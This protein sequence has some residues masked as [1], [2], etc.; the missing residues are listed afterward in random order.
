MNCGNL[1]LKSAGNSQVSHMQS[2]HTNVIWTG[3]EGSCGIYRSQI[4]S[5]YRRT[6]LP[7]DVGSF[8][9]LACMQVRKYIWNTGQSLGLEVGMGSSVNWSG[10]G[11]SYLWVNDSVYQK[12][13]QKEHKQ[14]E[15]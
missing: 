13:Y 15:F 10:R 1:K 8:P 14:V 11:R 4:Y 9:L 2:M 6:V 3:K 5:I 12:K 7:G